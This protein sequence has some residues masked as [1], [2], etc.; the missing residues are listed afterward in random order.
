MSNNRYNGPSP[1]DDK[2][3]DENMDTDDSSSDPSTTNNI[4]EVSSND[5]N[6]ES[7]GEEFWTPQLNM[8]EHDYVMT[9]RNL[10][11]IRYG[12]TTT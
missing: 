3:I 11:P 10:L 4:S 8:W 9:R 7:E 6:N 5:R 1:P 2:E 12:K